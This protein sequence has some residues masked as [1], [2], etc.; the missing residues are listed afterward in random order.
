MGDEDDS[1]V[2]GSS[3]SLVRYDNPV[4]IDKHSETPS[5]IPTSK[6]GK[7]KSGEDSS[8]GKTRPKSSGNIRIFDNVL[9]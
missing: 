7:A 8:Q 6:S 2:V 9:F 4:L 1:N 5:P 3:F